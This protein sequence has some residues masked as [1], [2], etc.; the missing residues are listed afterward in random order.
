MTNAPLDKGRFAKMVSAVVISEG[1]SR[2]MPKA[3]NKKIAARQA[4]PELIHA[5]HFFITG[6]H[7]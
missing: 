1:R 3:A 2:W 5:I 4:I 7:L 6:M